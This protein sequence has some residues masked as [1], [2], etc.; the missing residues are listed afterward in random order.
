[1]NDHSIPSDL[2]PEQEAIRAKCFHPRGQ[3][4]EF[5]IEDVATSIPARFEKIVQMHSAR[6]AVKMGA[7]SLTY[8]ELNRY[9]NRIARAIL[10]K[11]GFGSEPIALFFEK[12]IE[13]VAAIFGVLK[14]GK[15]YVV[16]DPSFPP[17][18]LQYILSDSGTKL[19]VTDQ[20]NLDLASK[21]TDKNQALITT[22]IDDETHSSDNFSLH[23]SPQDLAWIL[24][25]SGST[26]TPKGVVLLHRMILQ[27]AQRTAAELRVCADDRFTLLHSLSFGSGHSNL[28]LALLNGASI[29]GFDTKRENIEQVASWLKD[30][31]ITI[32]HSPPALFRQ[33]AE[34]L[35]IGGMHPDLRL[36]RLSGAPI[37][38][39][40]FELYKSRFGSNT[41]LQIAMGAS[42]MKGIC[43]AILD[44]SFSYPTEGFP[45][46]YP[47]RG[48]TISFL[49]DDRNE[50]FPREVG[51]IAVKAQNL[52]PGYWNQPSATNDKF[53][54]DPDGGDGRIYLTGDLGRMLSD[55]FVVH[56]G[57]KDLMVKIRGYRVDFSEVERALLEHPGIKEVGV[58]AWDREE[59]EKYLAGY[60]VPRRESV[61]NASEI[62]EFLSNKLPDYMIPTS[63]KFVE[64][65]PMT[66]GKLD[67]LALPRPDTL[68]PELKDTYVAPRNEV[69][70]KLA[71]IWS[72]VLQIEDIGVHD[73][74]LDLGGH[75]LTASRVL[76]RV[77]AC[78]RVEISLTAL[79]ESPT[80]DGL[81][82]NLENAL[83]QEPSETNLPLVPFPRRSHLPTTF[84]QQA[85]WLYDQLEPGSPA[86]NLPSIYRLSGE[87]DAQLL[88]QSI[89]QIIARHEVLRTVFEVVDGQPV[90]KILPVMTIGLEVINLSHLASESLQDFEVRRFA[91]V[92]GRQ[93]FDLARGPL[94]RSAL[95]RFA[96]NEYVFLL[97][98]HHI[99]FDG[100]SIGV[101]FRELSQIYNSLRNAKPCP[102]PELSIQYADFAIWQ[103]ERL[104]DANLESSLS[105]WKSQLGNAQ[106]R[107]ATTFR[108]ST[109]SCSPCLSELSE[110]CTSAERV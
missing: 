108:F 47:R 75:S 65:L 96:N 17:E 40:D 38:K 28:R 90:Q 12:S 25:T 30:E 33:L 13:L 20:Y 39:R 3:F 44:R 41:L 57:R 50:V 53:L 59:G 98:I 10:E 89:N 1:M 87:L 97:A 19:V 2:P 92:Q 80:L 16:L 79:F 77:L 78:F 62:R 71:E 42:E 4:V 103:R 95:L 63:F 72:E 94:L 32:L 7:R 82:R 46:G 110:S 66:N 5:P 83:R 48:V 14:T 45:I 100:W 85:L 52:S 84:G 21:V 31:C 55:G 60:I 8:D 23:I 105:Y 67:R 64:T 73:N 49:D 76:S 11:R 15:F 106:D 27:S 54:P 68:R 36:I 58:R 69:E 81:A 93:P 35:P 26:G 70:K 24:Y 102:L 101:F 74:F 86:Y 109:S 37:S 6:L 99:V 34:S 56:L 29:F 107:N 22:D 91:S 61:M 43:S 104:R 51:E 18:R 9:A 88:E